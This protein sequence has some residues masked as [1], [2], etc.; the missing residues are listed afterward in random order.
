MQLHRSIFLIVCTTLLLLAVSSCVTV[1]KIA[2]GTQAFQYKKYS[3]AIPML[4]TEIE[5][6]SDESIKAQ[7][8]YYLAESYRV[9][10]QAQLAASSYA[11]A[12][13]AGYDHVAL[14][15]QVQMLKILEKYDEAIVLLQKARDRVADH[16]DAVVAERSLVVPS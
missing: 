11:Q 6:E 12:V 10:D 1:E 13:E 4:K 9:T 2:D 14:L 3:K 8:L 7:K 15:K 16:A 5:K